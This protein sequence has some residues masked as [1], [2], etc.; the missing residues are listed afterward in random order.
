MD[1]VERVRLVRVLFDHHLDASAISAW[2][3][4]GRMQRY[5]EL[6]REPGETA[7]PRYTVETAALEVGLEPGFAERMIELVGPG[8][9]GALTT[10]DVQVLDRLRT[11]LEAGFPADA[12]AQLGRVYVDALGRVAETEARLFRF[13]V[14]RRL[15][16]SGIANSELAAMLDQVGRAANPLMEPLILYVHRRAFQRAI[17]E[18]AVLEVAELA[19][20]APQTE[21]LTELLAAVVFVDIAS[22]TPLV[23]SVGDARAAEV[24]ERF[25]R[26][27]RE[28][29]SRRDGTVVKQIGDAFMLTFDSAA[30]AV[31]AA[32]EIQ[33]DA[34]ADER[35]PDLHA[36]VHWGRVLYWEGDYVGTTVNIAAR[37]VG[38][39]AAG[40]VIVSA[41]VRDA[42]P[43]AAGV[44]FLPCGDRRLKG[45]SQPL[46]ICAARLAR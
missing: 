13:Y 3:A 39:A 42:I 25:S 11:A 24:L 4:S 12:L 40:E 22:F 5:V 6:L 31:L 9:R 19:G 35:L 2:A 37:L 30:N 10:E 28:R 14:A 18:D 1:D 43:P 32:V 8:R 36:A 17:R 33:R 20:V 45:V 34:R 27:V 44:A 26:L 16:S 15:A 46:A 23:E 21:H 38:E 41:A 29:V 7:G